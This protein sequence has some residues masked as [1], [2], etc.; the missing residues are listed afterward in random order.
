MG[1]TKSVAVLAFA[2]IALA[3]CNQAGKAPKTAEEAKQEAAKLDRPKPGQYTQTMTITRFEIPDA[4][5]E[6]AQQMKAAMGQAQS[7]DFCL[8]EEM[9]QEGYENMFRDI[10][11]DGQCKY[12]R[13]DVSGGKLDAVLDCESKAEGKG[14]ITLAGTVGEDGSEVT[15]GMDTL[16]PANP[17]GRTIIGMKMVSKRTGDCTAPATGTP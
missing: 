4:P 1:F 9:A 3:S 8:T 10:G 7:T 2:T 14:T 5:P 15:V 13:F 16:N 6:V 12:Q 17:M 11:K